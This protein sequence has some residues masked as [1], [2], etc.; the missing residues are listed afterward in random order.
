MTSRFK[1]LGL[2]S[3]NPPKEKTELY[4]DFPKRDKDS[5]DIKV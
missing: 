3:M 2:G 5:K 1:Y 4:K